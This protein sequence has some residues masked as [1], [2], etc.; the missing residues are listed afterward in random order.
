MTTNMVEDG[1]SAGWSPVGHVS[2]GWRIYDIISN[3]WFYRSPLDKIVG[4]KVKKMWMGL[5]RTLTIHAILL[6]HKQSN[7]DKGKPGSATNCGRT[8]LI[9][10]IL[11]M[12]LESKR[13][14]IS[15]EK[16][17][18]FSV[19]FPRFPKISVELVE[20]WIVESIGFL[21]KKRLL[22]KRWYFKIS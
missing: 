22:F 17:F 21:R 4:F 18:S 7:S 8:R 12:F 11:P 20:P 3:I 6:V 9:K 13:F 10:E 5:W 2:W 14:W 19:A 16:P 15:L 1:H